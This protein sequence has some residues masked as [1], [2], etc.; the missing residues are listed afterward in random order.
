MIKE[1][2]ATICQ[3]RTTTKIGRVVRERMGESGRA[4]PERV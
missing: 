3:M 2:G 1:G 4:T